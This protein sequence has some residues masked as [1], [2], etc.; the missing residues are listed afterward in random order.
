MGT[1]F[2]QPCAELKI[3]Y[4]MNANCKC[5]PFVPFNVLSHLKIINI[6]WFYSFWIILYLTS[7]RPKNL[8]RLCNPSRGGLRKMVAMHL[9]EWNNRDGRDHVTARTCVILL[10]WCNSCH[11]QWGSPQRVPSTRFPPRSSSEAIFLSEAS[12]EFQDGLFFFFSVSSK[13][14]LIQTRG[15]WRARF[16]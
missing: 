4:F 13:G 9:G 14:I 3:K 2:F 8:F 7:C 12:H 16:T 1:N 10:N 5:I 6:Y 15:A 11:T